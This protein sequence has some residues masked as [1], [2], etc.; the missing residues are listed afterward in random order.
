MTLRFLIHPGYPK[1]GST[2]LQANIFARHPELKYL[3]SHSAPG[4][5]FRDHPKTREFHALVREMR[6]E[7]RASIEVLWR[8]HMRPAADPYRLN[9][10]SDETFLGNEGSVAEIAHMMQALL[11]HAHVLIVLR[12]QV[13]VLRS[14]YDMYPWQKGD[15]DRRYLPF[16]AWLE[17]TLEQSETN[18]VGAMR[19][20]DIVRLY[21]D[22]FGRNAVTV[23][24]FDKLFR[25]PQ[26]QTRLCARLGI[27]AEAFATLIARPALNTA[28][29]H[30]TKKLVRR[31]LGPLKG[32]S[33]L[34]PGQ[35]KFV[36]SFL[37]DV[38]PQ[39]TTQVAENDRRRI[40][41]Y[42]LGQRVEDLR[43]L[44]RE[45]LIL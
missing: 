31:V 22:V 30:S 1:C 20:S 8:D 41:D 17:K 15:P 38:L 6:S 11:G 27:D 29:D 36:R 37:G 45:G 10:I 23:I 3:S 26:A 13:D 9:V 21:H 7:G 24:S 44:E 40:E 2:S 43:A 25:D 4:D 35:I 34:T 28:A 39:R 19:Y 42:F 5:A 16:P 12:D 33:F 32:S 14:V 18:V